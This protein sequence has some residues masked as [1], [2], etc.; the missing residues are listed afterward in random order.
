MTE[1]FP[2]KAVGCFSKISQA[3][4]IPYLFKGAEYGRGDTVL[5]DC[6]FHPENIIPLVKL[7]AAALKTPDRP[8]PHVPVK[9]F[10][11]VRKIAVIY[12]FGVRDTGGK[13]QNA[14]RLEDFFELLIKG[15]PEPTAGVI[16]P[17]IDSRL[18]GIFI[19][20]ATLEGAGVSI[21][22]DAFF[23]FCHE[24]WVSLKDRFDAAQKFLFGGKLPF[25]RDG[26]LQNIGLI[27]LEKLSCILF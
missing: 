18:D 5:A 23:V 17:K 2:H 16:L 12:S 10:A 21:T 20:F 14:L 11:D 4:L 27:N 24:I 8:K 1:S 22:K 25:K 13:I 6:F 26:G 19:G 9:A 7:I 15:C 3:K